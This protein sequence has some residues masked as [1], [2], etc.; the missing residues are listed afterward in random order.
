MFGSRNFLFAKVS[1]PVVPS[2]KLYAW[3]GN[4]NQ[5][6]GL[7]NTT[8]YS[9]PKQVGSA[10]T[11]T[12]VSGGVGH[13]AGL[14]GGTLKV[15]GSDSSG[16]I[17]DGTSGGN[18][19]Y[20]GLSRANT[21]FVNSGANITRIIT[22]TGTL[23]NWGQNYAG[24]L[25]LGNTTYYSSPV[26]VGALNNWAKLIS[27]GSFSCLAI[28][29]DGTLWSWG[30]NNFGQLGLVN[31]TNYSSPKQIGSDTDWASLPIGGGRSRRASAAIKT[32]GTLWTWGGG[33]YGSLGHSN[34]T[35]YSSPKQVGSGTT[36]AKIAN[37]FPAFVA[38][39]TDGTL[40]MWGRNNHGQLGLGNTTD[41]SS[42][43]QVGAL[44]NWATPIGGYYFTG[45][46]KTDGTLWSWGRNN[47]GQLGL[48]NTTSYSSPKQI[49]SL[50]TWI[51]GGTS[52]LSMMG[53]AT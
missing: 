14:V 53:I 34:T 3:G 23:F 50:T 36:W 26:Q 28:K 27:V 9:S 25:G 17:G 5:Q 38:V 45:C 6:L 46:I 4:N 18:R 31:T 42:P 7:P 41:Y 49:G 33:Q 48:G 12:Q 16:Q 21:S 52:N 30:Q 40:W 11:W 1:G 2:G 37:L 13:A 15:W 8:A 20:V 43:K 22:T 44:T 29:T 10:T 35:N 39:K 47:Y 19:A 24:A 32:N 51:S